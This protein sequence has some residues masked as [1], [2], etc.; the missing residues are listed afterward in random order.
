MS[1]AKRVIGCLS[2]F[3]ENVLDSCSQ[4][5]SRIHPTPLSETNSKPLVHEMVSYNQNELVLFNQIIKKILLERFFPAGTKRSNS[6][7][8][9]EILLRVLIQTRMNLPMELDA[10][11][12][13]SFLPKGV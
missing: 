7:W 2:K 1:S 6:S 13:K 5:H 10:R 11:Y 8:P 12:S 4:I 3:R 9:R